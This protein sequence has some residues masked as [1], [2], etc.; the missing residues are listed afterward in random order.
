MVKNEPKTRG[1]II[2][3]NRAQVEQRA[4]VYG[5][6]YQLA[7]QTGNDPLSS[8]KAVCSKL[9]EFNTQ[10]ILNRM[11]H[12]PDIIEFTNSYFNSLIQKTYEMEISTTNS[13]EVLIEFGYCPLV[14]MWQK[15]GFIGKQIEELCD[16]AMEADRAAAKMAGFNVDI[17]DTIAKGCLSCMMRFY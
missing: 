14:A 12:E 4:A 13:G 8:G 5:Y 17:S 7:L 9:G 11:D 16:I 15:Q 3:L 2:D 10:D 6:H 1:G